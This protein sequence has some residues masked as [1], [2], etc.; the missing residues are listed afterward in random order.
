MINTVFIALGSNIGNREDYINKAVKLL[1]A[2]ND[3]DLVAISTLIESKAVTL[4]PQPDYLNGVAEFKTILSARQLFDLTQDI[5]IQLGRK[6][7]GNH[8]PRT[9]D[10][11]ILL[12]NDDVITDDD[13]VIPH[14]LLH[15]REFV[16]KPL[17][18]LNPTIVHPMYNMAVSELAEERYSTS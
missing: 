1:T 17:L 7:K 2:N 15:E 12:F 18:E 16:M 3:I 10:L 8:D 13:L 14:P 6:T 9:I 4:M 11:D 5:E